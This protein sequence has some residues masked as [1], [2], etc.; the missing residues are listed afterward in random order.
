MRNPTALG[1]QRTDWLG[2]MKAV[3]IC[4]LEGLLK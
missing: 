3:V 1:H 2:T 4:S